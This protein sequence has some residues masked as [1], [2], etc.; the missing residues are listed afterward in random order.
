MIFFSESLRVFVYSKPIDMRWSFE[1]LSYLVRE[2]MKQ[3]L[4]FG[5]LYLF[6]GNN[7]R[8]LKALRYDGSGLVLFT[9]RM[10]RKRGFMSVL[11]LDGGEEISIGDLELIMHGSVIRKYL[12]KE[13]IS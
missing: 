9:K 1:R 2:E 11:D 7:R 4:D 10:E 12:P 6:L 8:R 5:D 3:D 13:K